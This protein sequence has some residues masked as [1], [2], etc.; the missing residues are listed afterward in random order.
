MDNNIELLLGSA[1]YRY[2]NT[3]LKYTTPVTPVKTE[4]YISSST[5]TGY[6][7]V[8]CSNNTIPTIIRVTTHE[9]SVYWMYLDYV[10]A[11]MTY[12]DSSNTLHC[13]EITHNTEYWQIIFSTHVSIINN[14]ATIEAYNYFKYVPEGERLIT[15][16][17]SDNSALATTIKGPG[18]IK[19]GSN[20]YP[21]QYFCVPIYTEKLEHAPHRIPASD[22]MPIFGL[23]TYKSLVN[24]TTG[25]RAALAS[26]GSPL[27]SNNNGNVLATYGIWR[28]NGDLRWDSTHWVPIYIEAGTTKIIYNKNH[29]EINGSAV[30]TEMAYNLLNG[31]VD[32]SAETGAANCL[33]LCTC[34]EPWVVI[35]DGY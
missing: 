31:H 12:V 15:I 27:V 1:L 16:P 28:Y 8:S 7:F 34:G 20:Y 5:Q 13:D 18:W 10:D 11:Q 9:P 30:S 22:C 17:Q 32:L 26:N 6:L 14:I 4:T 35:D 19:S 23:G 25:Q 3:L 2:N 33:F 21:E 29:W 24:T